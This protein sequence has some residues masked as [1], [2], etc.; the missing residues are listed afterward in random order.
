[1]P[2]ELSEDALRDVDFDRE[3]ITIR[4]RKGHAS[5]TIKLKA[6]TI[7]MLKTYLAKIG[8]K[9]HLFPLATRVYLRKAEVKIHQ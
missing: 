8:S 3:S 1:M 6:N 9:E 4:G 7:A 2:K 5:R